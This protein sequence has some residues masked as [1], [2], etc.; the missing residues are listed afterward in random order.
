MNNALQCHCQGDER[1]D[2]VE[3]Q[4]IVMASKQPDLNLQGNRDVIFCVIILVP[5][6]KYLLG[7]IQVHVG[8]FQGTV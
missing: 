5:C 3:I 4:R 8:T 7:N 1:G 2:G 6:F